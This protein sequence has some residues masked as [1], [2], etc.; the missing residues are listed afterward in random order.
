MLRNLFSLDR[1]SWT[2]RSAMLAGV[3]TLVVASMSLSGCNDATAGS[4]LGAG[5]GALAGQA[6][7]HNTEA[8]LIGTAVGAG[9]GYIIGNESDKAK[10]NRQY[11]Q[12]HHGRYSY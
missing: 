2:R 5:V 11:H 4:L 8:T 12:H 3:L 9:A 10:H 1:N 6:I 7:G